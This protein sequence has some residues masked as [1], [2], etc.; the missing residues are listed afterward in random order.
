MNDSTANHNTSY[1]DYHVS[2]EDD[3]D[4]NDNMEDEYD[5]PRRRNSL[6]RSRVNVGRRSVSLHCYKTLAFVEDSIYP[7]RGKSF[8]YFIIIK[9]IYLHFTLIFYWDFCLMKRS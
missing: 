7:V 9:I 5:T 1:D 4:N 3:G 2:A 6:T 8:F